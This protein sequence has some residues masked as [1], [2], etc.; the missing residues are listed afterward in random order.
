M[1]HRIFIILFCTWFNCLSAQEMS[2]EDYIAKYKDLAI[3]ELNLYAIPA[4]ITLA[5]GILESQNGNSKLAKKSNNHFGIKCHSNWTGKRVYHD[6]DKS[7]ECFRKYPTVEASYRD[8][9]IFLQKKRYAPLFELDISD[10]KGWAKG[11]KKAGY[12]TNPRYP[13]LLIQIIEDN[14][15]HQFDD[16]E[17]TPVVAKRTFYGTTYGWPYIFGKQAVFQN[18]HK[19]FMLSASIQASFSDISLLFG[20]SKLVHN[21]IGFGV[22]GGV[23]I[24][25]DEILTYN[26]N[27]GVSMS[28]LFPKREKQW[29]IR[30]YLITTEFEVYTPM[31]S[32]GVLR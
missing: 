11:L 21:N 1:V 28:L 23:S 7:Q 25:D 16:Y 4:S 6:D 20:G 13:Q 29:F 12:A 27:Y 2:R 22:L 32:F 17:N 8:H 31:I 18:I 14:N 19:R 5:Q 26:Y 30:S 3:D 24:F 9:S 10:Y 15:L